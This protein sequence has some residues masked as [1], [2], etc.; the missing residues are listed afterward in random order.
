MFSAPARVRR[1]VIADD[2]G[3]WVNGGGGL[4]VPSWGMAKNMERGRGPGALGTYVAKRDEFQARFSADSGRSRSASA[5]RGSP[6][7]RSSTPPSDRF[8]VNLLLPAAE[9]LGGMLDQA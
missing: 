2:R 8:M 5:T 4:G 7:I 3:A 9:A 6:P 1:A